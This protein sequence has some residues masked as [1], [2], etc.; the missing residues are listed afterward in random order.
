MAQTINTN[1]VSLNAQR[2]LSASQGAL[3]TSMQRLSSGLRVNSAKDDYERDQKNLKKARAC[4]RRPPPPPRVWGSN[5]CCV[6]YGSA[7]RYRRLRACIDT[8][9]GGGGGQK[10]QSGPEY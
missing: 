2:N 1:L 5:V 10:H 8:S 9:I 6:E 7:P 4:P 3:A